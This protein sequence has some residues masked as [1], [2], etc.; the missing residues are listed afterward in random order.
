[1]VLTVVRVETVKYIFFCLFVSEDEYLKMRKIGNPPD[2]EGLA[3]KW[4]PLNLYL[5]NWSKQASYGSLFPGKVP[6]SHRGSLGT[7][8]VLS[9]NIFCKIAQE[10]FL[11][12][13][14]QVDK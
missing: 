6:T 1:M 14:I 8:K 9:F 7:G 12:N 3:G 5:L 11:F 13:F 2:Q 10:K 4:A